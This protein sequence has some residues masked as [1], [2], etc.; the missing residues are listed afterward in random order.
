MSHTRICTIRATARICYST[1]RATPCHAPPFL[2]DVSGRNREEWGMA[3]V[4][5]S[6]ARSTI[7]GASY[8][9]LIG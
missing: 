4:V 1:G 9:R 8:R 2:A 3:R 5:P 6:P 7:E